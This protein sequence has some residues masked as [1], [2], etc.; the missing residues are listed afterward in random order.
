MGRRYST[1]IIRVAAPW[2]PSLLLLPSLRLN[3]N[4]IIVT[5]T[6]TSLTGSLSL[7]L[8]EARRAE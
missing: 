8:Q 2:T 6:V 1:G 4:V 7:S 3:L 5:V